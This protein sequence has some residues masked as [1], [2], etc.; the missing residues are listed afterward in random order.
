MATLAELG[1]T[2]GQQI[3]VGRGMR[4]M[5][6]GAFPSFYKGVDKAPIENFFES[7][8]AFQAYSPFGSR[9]E[10]ELTFWESRFDN[11]Q[12]KYHANGKKSCVFE[13][14]IQTFHF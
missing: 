8:M 11:N 4:N 7:F 14:N 6:P 12:G 5:A 2:Y 9:S 13:I 3:L 1:A 10:L